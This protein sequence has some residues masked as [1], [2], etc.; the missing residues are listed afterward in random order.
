MQEHYDRLGIA[1]G[2]TPEEIRAAYHLKLKEFPAHKY[3]QEFKA[4]RAAYEA[5]KKGGEQKAQEDYLKLR[6]VQMELNTDLVRAL[7]ERAVAESAV[8]LEE[9]MRLTF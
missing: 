4:I 6:P 9:L 7:R 1:E 5:L 3:P 2:A 8:S